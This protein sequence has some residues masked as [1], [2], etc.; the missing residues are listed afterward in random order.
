MYSKRD[1]N[2]QSLQVQFHPKKF[3]SKLNFINSDEILFFRTKNFNF[4]DGFDKQALK[5]FTWMKCKQWICFLSLWLFML[6]F[7]IKS[8]ALTHNFYLDVTKINFPLKNRLFKLFLCEEQAEK[9]PFLH[10]AYNRIY[11]HHKFFRTSK[12]AL[13]MVVAFNILSN[14]FFSIFY[15]K[16]L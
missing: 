13:K 9:R 7:S 16:Q 14:D 2:V 15:I 1:I 4:S 5:N 11:M 12:N 6:I 3:D 10:E 8:N